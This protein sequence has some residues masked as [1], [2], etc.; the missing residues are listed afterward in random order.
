MNY[1]I[2]NYI[3]V[4]HALIHL[5][6]DKQAGASS[7]VLIYTKKADGKNCREA[8][9]WRN[10]RPWV[11]GLGLTRPFVSK[12]KRVVVAACEEE[13]SEK[14]FLLVLPLNLA[15]CD[16]TGV[17]KSL[18]VARLTMD[19]SCSSLQVSTRIEIFWLFTCNSCQ[20]AFV[21]VE[22]AFKIQETLCRFNKL[23]RFTKFL[24][25]FRQKIQ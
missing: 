11:R 12:F 16:W 18:S 4:K 7:P 23:Y 3:T 1:N 2:I 20:N 6:F 15:L 8:Y 17:D 10:V 24:L 9:W 19:K 22:L 14:Y 25:S 13:D 5:N 21:L